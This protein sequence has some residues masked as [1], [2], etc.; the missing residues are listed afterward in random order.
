[1]KCPKCGSSN[2]TQVL[3]NSLDVVAKCDDCGYENFVN[4]FQ[5]KIKL[6]VKNEDRFIILQVKKPKECAGCEYDWESCEIT[7]PHNTE[8]GKTLSEFTTIIEEMM[9]SCLNV[10]LTIPLSQAK[11]DKTLKHINSFKLMLKQ[12]KAVADGLFEN[13]KK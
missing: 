1:M 11:E 10:S 2:I 4:E 5:K 13:A 3:N 8:K 12:A 9:Y 7:C 6:E